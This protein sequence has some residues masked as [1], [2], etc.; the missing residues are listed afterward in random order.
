MRLRYVAAVAFL[1]SFITWTLA[2]AQ[3]VALRPVAP[4]VMTGDD[5]GFEIFALRGDTPVG[6]IVVRVNGRWVAAELEP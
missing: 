6:R 5:L 2:T 3:V 1:C 4:K